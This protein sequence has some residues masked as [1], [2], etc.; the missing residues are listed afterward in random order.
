MADNRIRLKGHEKFTLREG[1]LNKGITAVE[2]DQRVFLG[3]TGPD[4]LGVGNNMVKSIRYWVRAFGL[5]NESPGHGATITPLGRL[6]LDNDRYFEDIFTLWILHSNIVKN[7]KEATSWYMFF[8]C[9]D[10]EEFSKDDVRNMVSNEIY[11]FLGHKDFMESSIKDDIDVLLNMYCKEKEHGYD[12]EDKNIS[13][14]SE[15]GLISKNKDTYIKKQPDLRKI[16]E[17]V[18][19]YELIHMFGKQKSLSIDEIV[20]GKEGLGRIYNLS[21]VT[22]NDYLDRIEALNF[23]KVTRTAGLDIVYKTTDITD[24]IEIVREYYVNQR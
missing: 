11:K 22:I 14:L 21:R 12:P 7:I 13:P 20:D 9:C 3:N 19:L 15:L 23:I 6:I 5:I 1:W 10:V 18:L 16:N 24:S 8:N 2:T 17:Y 4:E